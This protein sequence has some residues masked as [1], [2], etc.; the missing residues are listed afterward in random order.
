MDEA[1]SFVPAPETFVLLY[2]TDINPVAAE[3]LSLL[4][5]MKEQLFAYA[6]VALGWMYADIV[7]LT[8]VVFLHEQGVVANDA[9]IVKI[10]EHKP[11]F[12]VK[13]PFQTLRCCC[14]CGEARGVFAS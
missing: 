5:C 10:S 8:F 7:Q 11:V 12:V 4:K 3:L 14:E 1:V 13:L 2:D 9:V 6:I